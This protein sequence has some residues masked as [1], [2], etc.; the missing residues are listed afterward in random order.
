VTVPLPAPWNPDER[1]VSETQ[2]SVLDFGIVAPGR[3]GPPV[4]AESLALAGALDELGYHRLWL[5][6]HHEAHYCWA[7]PEVVLAA[8][9]Q[10]TRRIGL[11]TAALLLP[12]RNPLTVAESFRALEALTPGRIALGVC[13]SVP[14]DVAALAALAGL[15]RCGPEDPAR[16]ASGFAGRLDAMLAHLH[17]RFPPGH[18]FAAGATPVFVPPPP[19]WVMGSSPGSAVIA[20]E[21]GVDYAYSVFHRGSRMQPEVTRAYRVAHPRGRVALAA[22]CICAPTAAEAEAQ[23]RLVEGWIGG[24]IRVVVSGTPE[25]CRD[26]LLDLVAAFG[27]DE[28]ILLHAWHLAEPR[29]AAVRAMAEALGLP[30]AGGGMT[31]R[32]QQ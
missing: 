9:A 21:R 7:G 18:R 5:S 13:A 19:V 29:L 2:H 10:R 12:L 28:L 32:P 16:M 4:L 15:D 8:L 27:A 1:A 22:S 25:R 20:A 30:P 3:A 31:A 6:E 14:Q 24:D 23:R 26:E 11:G 17:G